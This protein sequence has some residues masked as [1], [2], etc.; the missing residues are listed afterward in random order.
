MGMTPL[1][2]LVM[3]TRSGDIDPA[4]LF[5][6]H[7]KTGM[8]IGELED[9]LNRRSG[10]VGLSGHNDMRDVQDAAASGDHAAQ[11][12]FDV[13]VHRLKHYIGGYF[14]Q[15][16]RLDALVF[17]AGVG[18]NSPEVRARAVEGLGGLG[19]RLD[20]ARNA[21]QSHLPRRISTD[22]SPVAVLVVPTNEELE[23]ARQTLSVVR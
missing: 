13:Y 11:L 4:V 8:D 7:R 3:G 1:E 19:I 17:T 14:A 16:G 20:L 6:L 15:L 5:Y 10:L 22:D 21:A 9:L 18:E 12:A 2:G 23:I